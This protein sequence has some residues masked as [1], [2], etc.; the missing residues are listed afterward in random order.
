MGFI[1]TAAARALETA[2]SACTLNTTTRIGVINAPPP[3]PVS[4]TTNPTSSLA[5]A[6]NP[7]KSIEKV[8]RVQNPERPLQW[9]G[10]SKSAAARGGLR[11]AGATEDVLWLVD[12]RRREPKGVGVLQH[13]VD[14]P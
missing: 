3:M 11:R 6:T 5:S 14:L 12:M 13:R 7:S 4:P 9:C 8:P 10:C 1:T 2:A